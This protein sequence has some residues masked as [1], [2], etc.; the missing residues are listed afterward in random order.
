MLTKQCFSMAATAINRSQPAA[1]RLALPTVEMLAHRALIGRVVQARGGL[2]H[3]QGAGRRHPT[4]TVWE[5]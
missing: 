4:V 2:H 1:H 5:S 3:C